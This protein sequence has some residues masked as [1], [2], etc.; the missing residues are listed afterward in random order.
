MGLCYRNLGQVSS[1]NARYREAQHILIDSIGENTLE[2][3]KLLHNMGVV[4]CEKGELSD[5][6][7]CFE[8]SLKILGIEKDNHP[9]MVANTL[10]WLG[11]V[12]RERHDFKNSLT[13]FMEARG[14]IK[15]AEG[16]HSL[17]LAEIQQNLGVIYDDMNE[18]VKSLNCYFECLKLRRLHFKDDK[19]NDI[20]ETLVCIANIL[21][22]EHD[23]H[24][25]LE[26][27]NVVL[28]A[29]M[30]KLLLG[31]SDCILLLQAYTDVL[32]VTK[33]KLE[34]D[35]TDQNLQN[36]I[37]FLLSKIGNVNEKLENYVEA[38]AFYNKALKVRTHLKEYFRFH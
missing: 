10:C 9:Q 16:D 37:A 30:K 27:F 25:T 14:I 33:E 34:L 13:R 7:E 18:V 11:K 21:F 24:K 22:R 20:C 15:S 38:I 8:K 26:I 36:H 1:A 28:S 4:Y 3:S 17:N 5:S 29:R 6:I 32:D 31:K 23:L 2:H 12:H 19:H 35:R